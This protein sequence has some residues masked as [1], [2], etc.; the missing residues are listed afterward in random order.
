[1]KKTKTIAIQ[2]DRIQSINKKTDTTL[3]LALE[4]Q[5]RN[6]K[7]YYYETRNLTYHNGKIYA[8]SKEIEFSEN[9]KKFY[10]IKK[11]KLLD[12]SKTNFVLMRQNP[13]FNMDYITATF[14]LEKISNKTQIVN[15]PVAVRNMPEKLYSIDF[16]KLMPPT[17]FTRSVAEI[18]KFKK[19]YKKIVIKPT[20]GYGGKNILFI[21]KN[22]NKIKISNYLKKHDHVMVQKFI[23][24]IK[25]GDK[26][27]FIIGG[28]IK[29]AIKRVPKKGSIVSNL[30]QGGKAVKTILTKKELRIAKIVASSLKRNNI[31]FAGIDLISD[32]L[33]GDI[34]ITSPTGLKN[35]K[36]L[37]GKNLAIDFWNYLEKNK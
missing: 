30:G 3:L 21:N 31:V 19:Q 17:M 11:K 5:R 6:Y 10:F 8:L 29:G 27:I 2:G 15:N 26:R 7:I 12:L 32:Y 28:D 16:L 37:T 34:N 13:P 9:K 14:L 1:M 35:F 18:E 20:H 22:I 36:D 4:A 33:T 24:Q 25:F 23:P